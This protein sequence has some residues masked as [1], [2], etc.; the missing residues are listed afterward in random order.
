MKFINGFQIYHSKVPKYPEFKSL[1][2]EHIDIQLSNLILKSEDPR[3]A[4]ESLEEF[5]K[6][7]LCID[8]KTQ[9]LPVKYASRHGYGRHYPECPSELNRDGSTN[10]Y[11][12]K[13]YSGLIS[14]PR[15]IKNTLFE[16][17]EWTD[18]DQ[19]KGHPTLLFDVA[20]KSK[21]P[22]LALKDYL[23]DGKFEEYVTILSEYYSANPANPL[24]KKHVK[25]LFNMTIYGGGFAS[26]VA[27]VQD[28]KMKSDIANIPVWICKPVKMK[29]TDKKHPL[30]EAFK[31]DITTVSELIYTSNRELQEI[32]CGGLELSEKDTPAAAASKLHS[33]KGRVMSYFCQT[34]EHEITY[35]AYKFAYKNGWIEKGR[36]SWGY[37]GFT[38]PP[39]EDESIADHIHELNLHVRK[40]TGLPTVQFILK[41]FEDAEIMSNL[42]DKRNQMEDLEVPD[43]MINGAVNSERMAS[44]I[45]YERIKDTVVY[46]NG[47]VYMRKAGTNFWT[48]DVEIFKLD[49]IKFIADAKLSRYGGGYGDDYKEANNI[50]KFVM[51]EIMT[52]ADEKFYEKF[53]ETTKGRTALEDG[54]YD[55]A[56]AKFYTWSEID[57]PYFTCEKAPIKGVELM[58]WKNDVIKRLVETEIFDNLYGDKKTLALQMFARNIAGHWEDKVFSSYMGNRNSGKGVME[59]LFGST[60]GGYIQS[61]DVANFVCVRATKVDNAKEK[62][63]MLPMEFARLTFGQENSEADSHTK[64]NGN[65]IKSICSGTDSHQ[66]RHLFKNIHTFKI[67]SSLIFMG[68]DELRIEPVDTME[69]CVKFSSSIQFKDAAWIEEQ[70]KSGASALSMA[71]YKVADTSILEK[72][73]TDDW[74]FALFHLLIDN[75]RTVPIVIPKNTSNDEEMSLRDKILHEFTITKRDCDRIPRT[76]IDEW[77]RVTEGVTCSGPK[78]YEEL[79]G[80]GVLECKSN[81]IRHFKGIV[82]IIREETDSED[83]DSME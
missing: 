13:Q 45:I 66:A 75:Y 69:K 43:D 28:G 37:D 20:T 1:F 68:N 21:I 24:T 59:K 33:R 2:Y 80:L 61:V 18:I 34:I 50:L 4:D 76:E 31:A 5:R 79:R 15:I 44:L 81:G 29:N 73:L 6:L 51:A 14:M 55:W 36:I 54:V 71:C 16:Y 70:K 78:V 48:S 19:K 30:Y 57:F 42:I 53:N 83:L 11:H 35:Q 58:A 74:R 9:M 82:R 52:N 62:A 47:S 12:G 26:W 72:C 38:A 49:L 56:K 60:F 27:G 10:K 25:Q 22:V 7:V 63:W 67:Q 32:V 8:A 40:A 39:F 17:Q 41:E 3:I 64:Y 23:Q 46:T 65:L 77:R